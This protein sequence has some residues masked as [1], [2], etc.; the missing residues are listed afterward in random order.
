M[1]RRVVVFLHDVAAAGIALHELTPITGSLE[2]AYLSLTAES[3]EYHS[4]GPEA[5]RA[6]LHSAVPAMPAT[7]RPPAAPIDE[8]TGR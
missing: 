7:P 8:E 6:D 2:D 5:M 1:I 3:V 4:A